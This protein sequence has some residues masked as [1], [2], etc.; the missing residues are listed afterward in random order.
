MP[1]WR[2][3]DPGEPLPS[4]WTDAIEELLSSYA[5]ANFR[6]EKATNT[7]LR[8]VAGPDD[9]QV[10]ISIDGHPRYNVATVVANH[11]GGP[12]GEYDVFVT[13]H[14]DVFGVSGGHEVIT[15][16]M[17]FGL[18][19]GAPTGVGEEALF[20]KVAACSW[21]GAKITAVRQIVGGVPV[22][23]RPWEVGDIKP[24]LQANDHPGWVKLDGRGVASPA[25]ALSRASYPT[26]FVDFMVALGYVGNGT[27]TF[28]VPDLRGRTLVGVDSAGARLTNAAGRDLTETGGEELHTLTDA[29]LPPHRF[30][31]SYPGG[32]Q[33]DNGPGSLI[34]PATFV[35]TGG[36]P[37]N[38]MP[39]YFVGNWFVFTG[40]GAAASAGGGG[41]GAPSGVG[42]EVVL[43]ADVRQTIEHGLGTR[44]IV[45]NTWDHDTG[46]QVD[47]GAEIVD[48]DHVSLLSS[49]AINLD[50]VVIP[51]A[52]PL[53]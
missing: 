10:G 51:V 7:T 5:G 31:T 44:L 22:S 30:V 6:V 29:E 53:P 17:A 43:V 36:Q 2:D 15:S 47:A 25:S 14:E 38:N 16:T 49:E 18:R 39:P 52:S 26:Q 40:E 23:E 42:G 24:S 20:R 48:D 8:V 13:T 21:D 45:V 35:D 27:T 32:T 41:S 34:N 19:I 1:R 33:A 9:D 11:P 46:E 28:G 3:F 12:A 37:H 50:L 4:N